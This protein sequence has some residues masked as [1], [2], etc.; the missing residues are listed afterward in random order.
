MAAMSSLTVSEIQGQLVV[1]SR[2]IAEELGI[3]HRGLRQTIEKYLTELQ[4]FG[5]VTFEMSKPLEASQGGRPER[6]CYLNEEQ[7]T[8]LMTLSR[9]TPQVVTCKQQ[10]VK[11]FSK[12][13][14]AIKESV[15][16]PSAPLPHR[17]ATELT[18][19]A[20]A[21]ENINNLT[22]QQLLRDELI[23]ELSVKRGQRQLAAAPP[24]YTIVK[25]RARELGYTTEQIGN[26]ASL[27]A[28]VAKM[29]TPAFDERVGKYRV[30]H[31]EVN[32]QLDTAIK[33]YFGLKH[34]LK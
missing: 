9:N 33:T 18:H 34:A 8:F 26:G 17:D 2:L 27:G 31:Y 20:I 10:L 22:L 14:Q 24:Q 32:D 30:K 13:K 4:E 7:A 16:Q 12:A 28:F 11:A 1:D 6:Y 5:V 25:V 29:V 19:T 23:D 3:A 21:I 15:S